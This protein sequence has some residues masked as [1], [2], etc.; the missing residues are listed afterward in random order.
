MIRRPAAVFGK[1]IQRNGIGT[2]QRFAIHD[3]HAG[4]L[5]QALHIVH[6]AMAL[7][8]HALVGTERRKNADPV[9]ALPDLAMIFQGIR[10]V[11]RGAKQPDTGTG[12]QIPCPHIRL[13]QARGSKLPDRIAVFRAQNQI[14]VKI[15]PQFHV[16]PVVERVPRQKRHHPAVRTEFFVI[17]P[18]PGDIFLIHTAIAHGAPFVVVPIQPDLGDIGIA[19][20]LRNLTRGKVTVIIDDRQALGTVVVQPLRRFRIQQKIAVHKSV[21][22]FI[23]LL[24]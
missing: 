16:T 12:N 8:L 11:I 23:L 4:R 7:D 14:A 13:R 6:Y 17:R 10:R 18:L 9:T 20:V 1:A 19:L 2:E 24:M 5:S 21:H 3:L 15:L 22:D